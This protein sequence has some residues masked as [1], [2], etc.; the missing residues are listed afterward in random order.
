[1][2]QVSLKMENQVC[3][4]H[5]E[6]VLATVLVLVHACIYGE[7]EGKIFRLFW[8]CRSHDSHSAE[9]KYM[10]GSKL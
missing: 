1:M 7:R 5:L 9:S 4:Y 6:E 2:L 10:R 3:I 8:P